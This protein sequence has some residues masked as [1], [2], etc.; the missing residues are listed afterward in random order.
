MEKLISVSAVKD[1]AHVHLKDPFIALAVNALLDNVPAV[2][3][4][5][6]KA[7]DLVWV[8]ERD[9]DGCATDVSGYLFLAQCEEVVVLSSYVN[10][11]DF[12]GILEYHIQ[13]T[14]EDYDTHLCVFPA[15]DCYPSREECEAAFIAVGE[16]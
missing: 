7:G 11:Y 9:E 16:G 10:D 8:I 15:E 6:F 12:E 5:R 2:E 14:A 13:C 3:V 1:Y 4:S